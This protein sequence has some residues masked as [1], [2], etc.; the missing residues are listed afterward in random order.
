MD[1]TSRGIDS[2][3]CILR[4]LADRL[5]TRTAATVRARIRQSENGTTSAAQA[6]NGPISTMTPEY[7]RIRW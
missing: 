3:A 7:R 5:A 2:V 1:E 6:R 4:P